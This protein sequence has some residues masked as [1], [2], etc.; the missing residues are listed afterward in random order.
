MVAL[1]THS[2]KLSSLVLVLI[3]YLRG[4]LGATVIGPEP[5]A[6]HI[7]AFVLDRSSGV[8]ILSV[9]LVTVFPLDLNLGFCGRYGTYVSQFCGIMLLRL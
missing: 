6:W 4:S 2:A 5:C 7:F 8:N 1:G 9:S 3:L